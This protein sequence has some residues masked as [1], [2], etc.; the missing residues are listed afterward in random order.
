MVEKVLV[1][2]TTLEKA[3]RLLDILCEANNDDIYR[4]RKN[5]GIMNDGTELIAMS[6]K[7]EWNFVGNHF[8]YVF[9]DKSQLATLCVHHVDILERINWCCMQYSAIPSE[10]QWCAV[11]IDAVQKERDPDEDIHV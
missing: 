8:D 6:I 7:D 11:D 3:I 5:V 9:Y 4:R 10:F 2:S 1:L